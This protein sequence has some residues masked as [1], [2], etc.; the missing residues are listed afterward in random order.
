M[1]IDPKRQALLSLLAKHDVTPSELAR[2]AGVT[3]G[4]LYSYLK[5]RTAS[6]TVTTAVKLAA[7]LDEPVGYITGDA[8]VVDADEPMALRAISIVSEVSAGTWRE[9][10]DL[11]PDDRETVGIP[12]IP[13]IYRAVAFGVRVSGSSMDLVYPS[14]TMLVCVPLAEFHREPRVGDRVIVR[15]ER[16]D[17]YETTVKELATGAA[18][19]VVL[20]PR[21]SRP[22]HQ[23]PLPLDG[24]HQA[25]MAVVIGSYREENSIS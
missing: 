20:M 15:R 16:A 1:V 12:S 2:R 10:P 22:E 4:T 5:G 18:G 8:V 14:G 21:S 9:E 6:L 24:D 17:L 3:S 23:Q 7:A 11:P 25:I 19:Q 13:A